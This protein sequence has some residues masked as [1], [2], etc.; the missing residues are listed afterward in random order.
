MFHISREALFAWIY[1]FP[2]KLSQIFR[3]LYSI[4]FQKQARERR[5]KRGLMARKIVV[6]SGKGGVGKTTVTANLG[7]QLAKN[8]YRVVVCDLD[9]GLNN[10]DVV[11]GVE[12]MANFDVVDAVE[13]RCR[14]KQALVR[15]PRYPTLYSLASNRISDRYVSPQAVRLILDSL[16]PQFDFILLDSPAGID[17]GFHRAVACADEALLVTT[18]H[19]SAMRDADRV[20]GMLKGYRLARIGLVVNMVKKELVRKGEIL[21]PEEISSALRV[22]LTAIVPEEDK[23]FLENV[24]DRFRAFRIL[25]EFYTGGE[26][27]KSE[28]KKYGLWEALKKGLKH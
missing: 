14:P 18:P 1:V 17:D 6:T 16:S 23:I 12:N 4:I 15:H 11:L 25:A 2:T 3:P 19:I 28:G 7:V 9:F 22:P 27:S 20:A 21:T 13:G 5:G 10:V 24:A 26:A 8:G